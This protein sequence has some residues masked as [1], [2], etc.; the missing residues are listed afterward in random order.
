MTGYQVMPRLTPDEYAELEQ[1]IRENGVQVPITVGPDGRIIDGHHRDEIARKYD[2]HCPRVTAQGDEQKLRSLAFSL[3][4][5]RRHLTREQKRQIIAE[6]LK[7]DPQ[8]SNR[9]HARRTGANHETV[10]KVREATE[11]SGEIRHFSERIDP[12][13][14]N[15]SQLASR[16]RPVPEFA[17]SDEIAP[18]ITAGQLDELNV[19]PRPEPVA[20]P[21]PRRGALADD[22]NRIG[23][24]IRK[25][26]EKLEALT[27]DDRYQANKKKV[28]PLLRGHLQYAIEVTTTCLEHLT[29]EDQ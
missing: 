4:L 10:Q 25:A 11:E 17:P 19:Q 29:G 12:R 15:A 5:H 3:N 26:A 27:R 20:P 24:E 22:A 23:W 7:A 8:L 1:S 2:L 18:G 21:K 9:E 14:G 6:S 16:P 13:T 28:T